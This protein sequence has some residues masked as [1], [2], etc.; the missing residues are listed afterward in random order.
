MLV[1]WLNIDQQDLVHEL[2]PNI[3]PAKSK[4]N[5]RAQYQAAHPPGDT[6]LV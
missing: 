3:R 2:S 5:S 1:E 6:P 4:S